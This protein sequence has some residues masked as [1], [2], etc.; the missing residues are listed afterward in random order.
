MS[1]CL[2]RRVFQA[3]RDML[4]MMFEH[5]IT[6]VSQR[7]QQKLHSRET[8]VST[9]AHKIC[10]VKSAMIK[11]TSIKEMSATLLRQLLPG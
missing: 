2:H 1:L 4:E 5:L 11:Y 7:I 6:A 8:A 3:C 10:V 9:L